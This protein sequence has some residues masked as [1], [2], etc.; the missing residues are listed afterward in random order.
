MCT[1]NLPTTNETDWDPHGR[2]RFAA[3]QSN[4]G[5][6]LLQSHGRD[7]DDISSIVFVTQNGAY[8]KSDAILGITEELNP[9]P[10][11]PLKP[12]AKLA[13]N[14]IPQFVRDLIYDGVADNRYYIM[15]KRL[16]CRFDADGE[17]D[18]RFV[19]DRLAEEEEEER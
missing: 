10:I 1:T 11:L 8:I 6:S 16:E 7:A 15:G 4:V 18:D 12:F 3:L 2:L 17:F 13:T 19:D 5:K 9:L 14:A